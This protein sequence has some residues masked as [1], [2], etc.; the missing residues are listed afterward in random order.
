VVNPQTDDVTITAVVYRQAKA[1]LI[2]NVTDLT[3]N[4][5]LTCTLDIINQ[6]TGLPWTGVLGPAIPA[7]PG[8][9]SVT[10]TNIEAP[11]LVTVTSSAGGSATSGVTL[12]RQ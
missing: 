1:R 4:I 7:A 2:I 9:Y 10:F 8:T 5:T 3:P 6:A 11:N 12:L